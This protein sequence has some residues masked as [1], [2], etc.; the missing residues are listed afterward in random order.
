[1]DGGKVEIYGEE[2]KP[3]EGIREGYGRDGKKRGRVK[4]REGCDYE[5]GREE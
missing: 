5:D 3:R 2:R 4:E 1:M